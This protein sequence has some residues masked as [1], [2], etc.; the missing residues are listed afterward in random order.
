[1]TEIDPTCLRTLIGIRVR[2]KLASDFLNSLYNRKVLLLFNIGTSESTQLLNFNS[3]R[4]FIY[5]S[6]FYK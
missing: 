1:M 3:F 6:Y 5:I 2:N 4:T